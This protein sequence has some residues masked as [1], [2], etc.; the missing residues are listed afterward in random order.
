VTRGAT[1]PAPIP[2]FSSPWACLPP[3]RRGSGVRLFSG[4]HE[5]KKSA[6]LGGRKGFH[7]E[8]AEEQRGAEGK[9]PLPFTGGVRGGRGATMA[10]TFVFARGRSPRR[11]PFRHPGLD[12][13][14]CFLRFGVLSYPHSRPIW[15]CKASRGC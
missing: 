9:G 11:P 4:S 12:P 1:M 15:R 13:G 6:A 10:S 14:P 7:A 2:P 3:L 8:T 5:D